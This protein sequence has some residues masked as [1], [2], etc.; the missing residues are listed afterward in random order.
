MVV[1]LAPAPQPVKK[2][3]YVEHELSVMLELATPDLI[4]GSAFGDPT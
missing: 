4:R 1:V 2:L 3:D